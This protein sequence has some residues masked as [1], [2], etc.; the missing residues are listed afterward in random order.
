MVWSSMAMA[1]P[2]SSVEEGVGKPPP[3][4]GRAVEG[5]GLVTLFSTSSLRRLSDYR[6]LLYL[7]LRERKKPRGGRVWAWTRPS[8]LR[9]RSGILTPSSTKDEG[10]A[11]TIDLEP[12][13]WAITVLFSTSFLEKG[14]KPRGERVWAWTRPS[15]PHRPLS[16]SSLPLS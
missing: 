12:L 8:C 5:E 11:M 9:K 6:T 7:F 2:S 15:C 16:Y 1:K 14:S 3:F 10:L 4:P 13:T